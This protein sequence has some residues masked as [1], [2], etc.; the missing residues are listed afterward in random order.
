MEM[1]LTASPCCLLLLLP[2]SKLDTFLFMIFMFIPGSFMRQRGI[3]FYLYANV[4]LELSHSLTNI[5]SHTVFNLRTLDSFLKF[6]KSECVYSPKLAIDD[7]IMT[8]FKVVVTHGLN[9]VL[10][11]DKFHNQ[12]WFLSSMQYCLLLFLSK[13]PGSTSPYIY[14][15]SPTYF[16]QPKPVKTFKKLQYTQKSSAC[17]STHK[18]M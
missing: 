9:R 5:F 3:L 7:P 17:L 10:Q 16:F 8:H 15:L 11:T 4:Q 13:F 18:E 14:H 1:L 12:R 6:N 2:G